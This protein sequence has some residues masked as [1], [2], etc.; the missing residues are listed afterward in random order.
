[1]YSYLF[2]T[3]ALPRK[4]SANSEKEWLI[5]GAYP[6]ALHVRWEPPDAPAISAVAVADEPESFW[7]GH[8]QKGR[9]SEW[10]MLLPWREEWGQASSPGELNGSSGTWLTNNVLTPLRLS[11]GQTWITD[12]LDV[13]HESKGAAERLDA[14]Q[15]RALLA[16]LKIQDRNLPSHP[17]EDR[18]VQ[19]AQLDRLRTELAECRPRH[20]VTLGNAALRVFGSL[21][22]G[23]PPILSLSSDS[24]YG[25]EFVVRLLGGSSIELLPLAH[26][27][28]PAP[29]QAAHATWLESH[30]RDA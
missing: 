23:P 14:P 25:K 2:G 12:C 26:P 4:P 5:L 18:I 15:M 17:N 27:G 1:M 3:P 19:G 22:E 7:E 6:S 11:R 10:A 29:Y 24:S 8:D 13:Y 28:A 20:V 9:I 16:E 30:Q 21:I